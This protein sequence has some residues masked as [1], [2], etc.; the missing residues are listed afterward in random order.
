MQ[1]VEGERA[2][3]KAAR[4]EAWLQRCQEVRSERAAAAEEVGGE[5]AAMAGARSQQQ[6]DRAAA[7]LAVARV[8]AQKANAA[9]VGL[10][11]SVLLVYGAELTCACSSASAM[12]NDRSEVAA[13]N[14]RCLEELRAAY[15]CWLRVAILRVKQID[16]AVPPSINYSCALCKLHDK[17][18][19]ARHL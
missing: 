9:Q 17:G 2:A 7:A 15:I 12:S 5:E 19:A 1:A 16:I 6:Y 14:C 18:S 3:A 10:V 13:V 8:R 4:H 11:A